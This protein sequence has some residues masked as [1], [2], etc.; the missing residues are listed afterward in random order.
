MNRFRMRKK[1]FELLFE[2]KM[3]LR[4]LGTL[5]L[6][7]S[8]KLKNSIFEMPIIPQTLNTNNLRTTYAKPINL[9][10]IRKL[11]KYSLKT[12]L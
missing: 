1:T 2:I 7:V 8:E 12:L 3:V 5:T 9:R 11:I 6:S 10:T 4:K